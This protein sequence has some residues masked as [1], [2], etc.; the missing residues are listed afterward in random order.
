VVVLSECC[1]E[2]EYHTN[3]P[4]YV[5]L[6]TSTK[7]VPAEVSGDDVTTV[8][9][10]PVGV[11]AYAVRPAGD[12]ENRGKRVRLVELNAWK[13]ER[14]R[15]SRIEWKRVRVSRIEWKRVRVSRIEWKR[16]RV[17]RIE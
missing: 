12:P 5:E 11:V 17:S 6:S 3:V 8:S 9:V 4:A 13:R 15:V 7:T 2:Q 1:C 14:V 16:V 10:H